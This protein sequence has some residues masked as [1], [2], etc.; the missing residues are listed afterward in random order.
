MGNSKNLDAAM[1]P[2]WGAW[3]LFAIGGFLIVSVCFITLENLH[4]I[5]IQFVLL[6]GVTMGLAI[7]LFGAFMQHMSVK[8][9]EQRIL[10]GLLKKSFMEKLLTQRTIYREK[11]EK[12]YV[13]LFLPDD[14]I[15]MS[16]EIPFSE[17]LVRNA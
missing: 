4:A 11:M 2:E 10:V 17:P 13:G 8:V 6:P 5:S 14:Q 15:I 12:L 1:W 9:E 16:Q 3:V 7:M